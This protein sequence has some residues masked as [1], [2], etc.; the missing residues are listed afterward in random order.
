MPRNKK[1]IISCII[2]CI[3]LKYCDEYTMQQSDTLERF[4][5]FRADDPQQITDPMQYEANRGMKKTFIAYGVV[6]LAFLA[7]VVYMA[8]VMHRNRTNWEEEQE[9]TK[10]AVIPPV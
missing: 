8:V 9:K 7:L 3:K 5:T 10:A 2:Y 6:L 4:D 1:F